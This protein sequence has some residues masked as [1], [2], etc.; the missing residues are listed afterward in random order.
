MGDVGRSDGR[1]AVKRAG[2]RYVDADAIA[3]PGRACRRGVVGYVGAF[4]TEGLFGF[5]NFV[6]N[7]F[8]D[9]NKQ[10]CTKRLN[11]FCFSMNR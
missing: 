8:V 1:Q 9:Q 2:V 7:P 6:Y 4:E 3:G 10:E 11:Y 5:I